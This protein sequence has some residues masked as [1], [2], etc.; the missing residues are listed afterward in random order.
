[1]RMHYNNK[2]LSFL[3]RIYK[4]S[5]IELSPTS[6]NE[7]TNSGPSEVTTTQIR[8][9]PSPCIP[10]PGRFFTCTCNKHFMNKFLWTQK[11]SRIEKPKWKANRRKEFYIHLYTCVVVCLEVLI[12]ALISSRRV[13]IW[14]DSL[15]SSSAGKKSSK[16]TL[17]SSPS[18]DFSSTPS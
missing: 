13:E 6:I 8:D 9:H 3:S 10:K 7:K 16:D 5:L 1:M 12:S 4:T 15:L 14:T 2:Y 18:L 11:F 17:A